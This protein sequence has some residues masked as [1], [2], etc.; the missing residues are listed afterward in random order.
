MCYHAGDSILCIIS[1]SIDLCGMLLY[2]NE[3]S[4]AEHLEIVT[5]FSFRVHLW[6]LR[7]GSQEQTVYFTVLQD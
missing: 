5:S 3:K 2:L 4:T 6:G 1:I 7:A